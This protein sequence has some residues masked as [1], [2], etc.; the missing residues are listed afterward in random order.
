MCFKFP[1]VNLQIDFMFTF[2]VHAVCF[3]SSKIFVFR[4]IYSVLKITKT[5]MTLTFFLASWLT[6][7]YSC[8][9]VSFPCKKI[10]TTATDWHVVRPPSSLN[11]RRFR[12]GFYS[13]FSSQGLYFLHIWAGKGPADI[14]VVIRGAFAS[15]VGMPLDI[16]FC[17]ILYVK[18]S[19]ITEYIITCGEKVPRFLE[20][21]GICVYRCHVYF[22]FFMKDGL[23]L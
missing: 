16:N 22:F 10:W 7:C 20:N 11:V 15:S 5:K 17:T 14:N 19:S 18:N 12:F 4:R 21:K 23:K 1:K 3:F 6:W 8:S 13:Q 2:T 9:L